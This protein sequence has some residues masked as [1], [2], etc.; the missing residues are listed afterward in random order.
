MPRAVL[1]LVLTALSVTFSLT[2][3]YQKTAPA[4]ALRQ[5]RERLEALREL[6]ARWPGPERPDLVEIS[7]NL[8]PIEESG[9][10]VRR[11]YGPSPAGGWTVLEL[12]GTG[13]AGPMRLLAAYRPDQ[14]LFNAALLEHSETPGFGKRFEEPAYM[15][16]FGDRGP[17]RPIPDALNGWETE[18]LDAISGSTISFLGIADTLRQARRWLAEQEPAAIIKTD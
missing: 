14:S 5:E 10:P 6:F 18:V 4:I 11:I 1:A 17:A 3:V 16:I 2:V 13:Y 12:E 9:G 8:N 7:R 15:R